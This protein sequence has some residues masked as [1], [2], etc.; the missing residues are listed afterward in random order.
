MATDYS[1]QQVLN[2]IA[3]IE[4]GGNYTAHSK[5]SSASG[6]YQYVDGTWAGYGG[7]AHAYLAP[8]AVQDAKALHD[9]TN[10][11]HSYGGDINKAIMSWFLPAAVGNVK[12]ANAVPKGN[13]ISPNQYVAKVLK[14]LGAPVSDKALPDTPDTGTGV[15]DRPDHYGTIEGA[16]ANLTAAISMPTDRVF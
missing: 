8:P 3:A 9:I 6:K 4:S 13:G 2:A 12:L 10:K 11:I 16:L 15:D 7:Y 1:P 14:A 5:T